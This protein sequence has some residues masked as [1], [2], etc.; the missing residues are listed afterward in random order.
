MEH[1]IM[2]QTRE[3][4]MMFGLVTL[5]GVILYWAISGVCHLVQYVQHKRKT[6]N[7]S[8]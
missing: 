3:V 2:S 7:R 8:R 5:C 1:E 4:L 6:K